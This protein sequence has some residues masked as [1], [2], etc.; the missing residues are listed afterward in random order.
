MKHYLPAIA[1]VAAIVAA[2][3]FGVPRIVRR[4]NE[5]RVVPVLMYHGVADDPGNDVWTVSTAEFRSQMESLRASG[6]TSILPSD[7]ARARRGFFLFPKKPVVITF[8][9]GFQSNMTL[10]EPI[11]RDTG[12]K[13]ICYL[14]IG[15]IA[16]TP[17]ERTAYRGYPNLVWTEVRDMIGRG[18]F[19]FGIH[20]ISHT[21]VPNVQ[22]GEVHPARRIFHAKTGVKAVSYCYPYGGSSDP[23]Y[24]KVK[25]KRY[26]TA[27]VCDDTLFTYTGDADLFRIPRISVH[28]GRHDFKVLS[29]ER[30]QGSF[31]ATLANE[32]VGL[33]VNPLLENRK[34][35]E[36][37]QSD[38][39][40]IRLG[41]GGRGCV[42][43]FM[44]T[45]KDVPDDWNQ[46]DLRIILREPNGL[47]DSAILGLPPNGDQT[48]GMS[49]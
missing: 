21:P 6:F 16:D 26:T 11:L 10:A 1:G 22:A 18:T 40:V 47:F 31:R 35:G 2:V 13:A 23:I 15:H 34:T 38:E 14:I 32:G 27:M 24:N 17:E 37:I 49:L 20:S 41:G 9:D 36:T 33:H 45:W 44:W 28:G 48:N 12:M 4:C 29:C 5:G 8:D 46:E 7:I 3:V 39:G 30:A 25:A 43:E 19:S 42:R